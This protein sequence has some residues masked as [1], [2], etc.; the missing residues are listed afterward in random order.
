[1]LKR[2]IFLLIAVL[3]IA[4][5]SQ[6]EEYNYQDYRQANTRIQALVLSP[7]LTGNH[8][9]SNIPF[10]M[11]FDQYNTGDLNMMLTYSDLSNSYERQ[12]LLI[13]SIFLS[14]FYS[15]TSLDDVET[16]SNGLGD[17]LSFLWVRDNFQNYDQWFWGW[18][19]NASQAYQHAEESSDGPSS[20]ESVRNNINLSV[21]PAFRI[22][23][24]RTENITNAWHAYRIL[25]RL[26]YVGILEDKSIEEINALGNYIDELR[27]MRVYDFRL[28]YIAHLKLLDYYMKTEL[29]LDDEPTISYFT[30]L[31]DMWAFGISESRFKGK[32]LTFSL[33]PLLNYNYSRSQFNNTEQTIDLQS[34]GARLKM[35]YSVGKP[36]KHVVQFNWNTGFNADFLSVSDESSFSF[37]E[38]DNY[39]VSPYVGA[40]IGYFPT[41]RTEYSIGGNVG[42]RYIY[43]VQSNGL[44]S[45]EEAFFAG[46]TGLARW[47]FSPRTGLEATLSFNYGYSAILPPNTIVG[48]DNYN[49]RYAIQFNHAFF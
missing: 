3:P 33:G 31:N 18:E 12:D 7:S 46:L 34:Y 40:F 45:D 29:G 26:N 32:K 38:Y 15:N 37:R 19:I 30:E 6:I 22:G 47:W 36:L 14:G 1:M 44:E 48:S 41:T 11:T 17:N 28:T 25:Q 42:Y 9:K 24:G 23:F 49:L 4:I 35:D 20:F 27:A 13:S 10:N 43:T 2:I 5:Y 21:N 8:G 16:N 39:T